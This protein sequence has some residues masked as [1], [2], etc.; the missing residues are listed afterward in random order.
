MWPWLALAGGLCLLAEWLLYGRFRR[1]GWARA[2]MLF[3]R[4][5]ARAPGVLR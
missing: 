5:P 4:K 3:L 1:V 2:R